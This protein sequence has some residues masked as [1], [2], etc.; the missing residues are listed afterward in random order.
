MRKILLGAGLSAA[1][2]AN[3]GTLVAEAEA[4]GADYIHID[5]TDT[6]RMCAIAS[7]VGG[8]MMVGA[9]RK[10]TS[11]PIEVHANIADL[12]E[13]HIEAYAKVG[14][15]M[16]VIPSE[17][18]MGHRLGFMVSAAHKN[19]MKFGLTISPSGPPCLIENSIDLLDRVII[20]ARNAATEEGGIY[21][22][23]MKSIKDLRRIIDERHLNCVLC[24]DG[25]ANVNT[26]GR[27]V[28]AGADCI[29]ASR[30]IWNTGLSIADS[31]KQLKDAI[32]VANK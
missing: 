10:Y 1:T 26:I 21:E 15:N 2:D 7:N 19:G 9:I 14:A 29:E 32:A 20:Y 13:R 18:Y 25:A 8:P 30:S 24:S 16:I 12:D 22:P 5:A 23:A 27:L 3:L 6:K 4:G 17:V 11:L 28:E 31:I